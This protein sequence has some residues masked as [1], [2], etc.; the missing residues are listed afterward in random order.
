MKNT[1]TV[2]NAFTNLLKETPRGYANRTFESESHISSKA[3]KIQSQ[4]FQRFPEGIGAGNPL[5]G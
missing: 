3:P 4:T 5:K 1:C 2:Y